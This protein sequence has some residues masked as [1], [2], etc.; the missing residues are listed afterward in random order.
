[1]KCSSKLFE[2]RIE[3][4]RS[5]KEK[6]GHLNVRINEDKSLAGFCS[7]MR[8]ARRNPGNFRIM[9]LNEE[10]IASLDALGFD[11]R[12]DCT[13]TRERSSRSNHATRIR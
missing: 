9:K 3:D 10:R 11:W 6:H 12:L 5:Y 2:E 4:L 13:N 7:G 1:M 8:Y